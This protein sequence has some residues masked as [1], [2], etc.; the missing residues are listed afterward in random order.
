MDPARGSVT[1]IHIHVVLRP[2]LRT[3]KTKSTWI[4]ITI[5]SMGC[6]PWFIDIKNKT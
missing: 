6:V 3:C 2:V 5:I 4:I 1:T